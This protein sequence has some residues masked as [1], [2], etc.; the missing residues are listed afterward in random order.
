HHVWIIPTAKGDAAVVFWSDT[1]EPDNVDEKLTTISRAKVFLRRSTGKVEDLKSTEDKDVYR[2]DCPGE[3]ART[4]G[5]TWQGNG[6]RYFARAALPDKAGKFE[7]SGKG[8]PWER[9]ELEIL[10]RRDRGADAYQVLFRGQP[11]ADRVV[12]TYSVEPSS[13]LPRPRTDKEGH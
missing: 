9:L 13:R 4:L 1:P 12:V 7:A 6:C 8:K 3:D 11:A 5:A 10:P 2:L